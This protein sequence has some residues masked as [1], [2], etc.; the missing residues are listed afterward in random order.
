MASK[1]MISFGYTIKSK[2]KIEVIAQS[3]NYLGKHKYFI[4]NKNVM[5]KLDQIMRD[6]ENPES[7][8]GTRAIIGHTRDISKERI[9]NFFLQQK[10]TYLQYSN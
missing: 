4:N 2:E 10:K 7:I 9:R 6:D 5:D 8:E 1:K 3:N